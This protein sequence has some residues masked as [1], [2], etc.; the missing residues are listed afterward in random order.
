M[1]SLLKRAGILCSF[2]LIALVV[3]H[4]IF[5][6]KFIWD[7]EAQIVN[8]PLIHSLKNIPLFFTGG[9]FYIENSQQL[10]QG[11]YYRPL[12]TTFYSLIYHFFGLNPLAFHSLQLTIHILNT[13]LFFLLLLRLIKWKNTLIPFLLAILFLIHPMNSE[14]VSYIA[15]LQDVLFFF[16][17]TLA[18]HCIIDSKVSIRSYII[19]YVFLFFS[20]LSKETAL[21]FVCI[22]GV[23]TYLFHRKYFKASLLASGILII[24]YAYLRCGIAHICASAH[25]P[26]PI[27][28]LPF[29]MYLVQLP[30]LVIYY[31]KTFFLP[32]NLAIGQSWVIKHISLNTFY[33]PLLVVF[34]LSIFLLFILFK[35]FI[36]RH[37]NKNLYVFFILWIGIG[38][39]FHLHV[40]PL[41][42]TVSD[43]WFYM[44]MAGLIACMGILINIFID[45]RKLPIVIS[46]FILFFVTY[47][48]ITYQRNFDWHD[49]YTL[50][51]RDIYKT[52]NSFHMENNLGVELFRR[53]K[54]DEALIHF[55]KAVELAPDWHTP[56]MNIGIIYHSKK[57]YKKAEYAYKKSVEFHG[58]YKAYQNYISLLVE[59]GKNKDALQ[60][61]ETKAIHDFP[62]NKDLLKT[63]RG[64]KE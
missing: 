21:V 45:K 35:L 59:Q 22:S 29:L 51:S 14:T 57:Q 16:F 49:N 26:N 18:L 64:L 46:I 11:V 40:L 54:Y 50:F 41:D 24:L 15:N 7:D 23:Y 25:K 13:C 32:L 1:K 34:C 53:K 47:S 52:E 4:P 58:L 44:P 63:Y 20:F 39:T 19:A 61:I 37:P 28:D 6:N 55:K 9:T 3:Y 30:L 17:G 42:F 12:M 5:N 36:Q 43:R 31:I 56:W 60:F 27:G 38:L 33:I 48:Y 62:D 10:L 2:I 8:N